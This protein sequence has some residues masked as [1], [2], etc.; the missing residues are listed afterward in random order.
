MLLKLLFS[1]IIAFC[2]LGTYAVSASRSVIHDEYGLTDMIRHENGNSFVFSPNARQRQLNNLFVYEYATRLEHPDGPATVHF[3]SGSYDFIWI[4]VDPSGTTITID[5]FSFPFLQMD[6]FLYSV[7]CDELQGHAL[8][9]FNPEDVRNRNTVNT[10]TTFAL[11]DEYNLIRIVHQANSTQLSIRP[12]S[13]QTELANSFN[14]SNAVR[15]EHPDGPATV[16]IL[17]DP[18]RFVWMPVDITGTALDIDPFSYPFNNMDGFLFSV[19][20]SEVQGNALYLFNPPNTN[21]SLFLSGNGNIQP[22][23]IAGYEISFTMILITAVSLILFIVFLSS[24]HKKRKHI[25]S[26]SRDRDEWNRKYAQMK[27]QWD[28]PKYVCENCDGLAGKGFMCERCK[29]YKAPIVN[30]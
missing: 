9:L 12:N 23:I 16:G 2:F 13:R 18:F 30:K 29:N 26:I 1:F 20:C 7:W 11:H 25:K 24:K 17:T 6:G 5:P 14:I 27:S 8:Y 28:A 4:P 10:R 15:L 22:L 21:I 19:W 3:F